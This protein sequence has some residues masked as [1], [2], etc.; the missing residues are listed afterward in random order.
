MQFGGAL[1][2]NQRQ[3]ALDRLSCPIIFQMHDSF[4]LE[5]PTDKIDYWAGLVKGVMEAPVP[6]LN[7]SIPVDVEIG[8]NW[9]EMTAWTPAV[10]SV[11]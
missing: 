4:L 10:Q 2:M 8:R 11:S 7:T 9:G 1:L 5:V 3:V 6:G